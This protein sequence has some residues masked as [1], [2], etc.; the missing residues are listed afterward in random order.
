MSALL[1]PDNNLMVG[2]GDQAHSIDEIAEDMAAFGLLIAPSDLGPQPAIEAAGH[3]GQW[4]ITGD[5]HGHG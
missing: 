1:I 4:Q 5:L 3:E 2:Q